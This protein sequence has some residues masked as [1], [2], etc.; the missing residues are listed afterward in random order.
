MIPVTITAALR[1]PG[2]NLPNPPMLDALAGVGLAMWLNRLDPIA[3]PA[4]NP[5][6]WD[7]LPFAAVVADRGLWWWA[8]S[9]AA[10]VGPER[11]HHLHRRAPVDW[12]MRHRAGGPVDMKAGPDKSLR[13]RKHL[14]AACRELVWTG[15]LDEARV[16]DVNHALGWDLAPLDQLARLLAPVPAIGGL[17]CH[18]IGWVDGWRVEEGGL[19]VDA[20]L[21]DV[22]LRHL[23]F[24]RVPDP[25][26]NTIRTMLPLRPPYY[27]GQRVACV[28]ARALE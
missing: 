2:P 3:H 25:P 6:V 20:Y 26:T 22:R 28:Q 15:V 11:V 1:P 9:Q 16:G 13:V 17:G 19:A 23:P 14:W 21:D 12:Y 10:P 18:G 7:L 4:Y 8:V 5:R 24:E 27:G